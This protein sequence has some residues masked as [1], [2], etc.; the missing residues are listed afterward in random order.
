VI[1]ACSLISFQNQVRQLSKDSAS[2][3][4]GWIAQAKQVQADIERSK[5][6]AREIV[7]Q[8][9]ANTSLKERVLDATA[10]V[11]LLDKEVAF[12]ESLTAI[13]DDIRSTSTVLNEAKNDIVKSKIATALSR[14]QTANAAVG[15]LEKVTSTRAYELLQRRLVAVKASLQEETVTLSN[16]LIQLNGAGLT[17]AVTRNIAEKP[18]VT[19]E[20]IHQVLTGLDALPSWLSNLKRKLNQ[21]IFDSLLSKP[22]QGFYRVSIEHDRLSIEVEDAGPDV[23]QL[24]LDLKT[25]IAFLSERLPSE[26]Y[27]PL[28]Q[29]LMPGFLERLESEQ[30]RPSV[31]LS[32]GQMAEFEQVL[33]GV[34]SLAEHLETLQWDGSSTLHEWVDSAPR[35]WLSRQREHALGEV[36]KLLFV[37]LHE[38]KTVERVETQVVAN[39]DVVMAQ[40]SEDADDAWTQ[41]W[42]EETDN[43]A[44]DQSA[45]TTRKDA[46][47]EDDDASAWDAEF[48]DGQPP[49]NEGDDEGDAWGWGDEEQSPDKIT[50]SNG[51]RANAPIKENGAPVEKESPQEVTLKETYIATA[52]PDGVVEIILHVFS[53]AK[54]LSGPR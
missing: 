25:V 2:D 39:E 18:E 50:K 26:V 23:I 21:C 36:R 3:I 30:L 34:S 46:P 31:P 40:D 35:V 13:L 1:C 48:D 10:K 45:A 42:T 9:E 14:L 7:Q 8:A 27:I 53:D 11:G 47:E 6:A 19:I 51:V 54:N 32:T 49:L 4:D 37:G 33:E 22:K 17:I 24:L 15:R 12:N 29:K 5:Q 38:R 16:Q 44:A 52:V 20:S 28:S 41:E 43:A